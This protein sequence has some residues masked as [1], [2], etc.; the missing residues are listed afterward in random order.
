MRPKKLYANVA[1]P[2]IPVLVPSQWPL[3]PSVTS[4]ATDK[5]DNEMIPGAVHRSP[6]IYLAAE[7]HPGKPQ[8]EDRR[9]RLRSVIA[10]NGVPFLQLRSVGSY[11]KPGRE[12]ESVDLM[13]GR[14]VLFLAHMCLR[15]DKRKSDRV[16][17]T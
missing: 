9:W 6:G 8:L 13:G 14:C 15:S 11:S 4:V 12:N 16:W 1:V 3:A 7:K 10:S 17:F 2:P 5:G